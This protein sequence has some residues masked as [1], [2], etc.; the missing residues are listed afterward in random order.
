[1]TKKGLKRTDGDNADL[2]IA[3]YEAA[4]GQE[5]EY[6]SFNSGW[7]LAQVGTAADS[8]EHTAEWEARPAVRL[9][10]STW[11]RLVSTCMIRP[12]TTRLARECIE[13][14]GHQS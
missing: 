8:T 9:L 12:E 11:D 2:L 6:T 10:P 13:D 1:M 14:S 5:K 4:I 3:D 7:V